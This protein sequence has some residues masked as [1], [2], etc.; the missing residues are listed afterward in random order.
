MK[1]TLSLYA[2][3]ILGLL[4]I[5]G[6]GHFEAPTAS[7]PSVDDE[8]AMWNPQ[9]GEQIDGHAIPLV[10]D[11]YWE[12]QFGAAV[13][14]WQAPPRAIVIGPLGGILRFGPHSL[15]VPA[16]AV[17]SDVLITLSNASTTAI[18]ID[19]GPSP[20]TFNVPVTLVLS[21]MGTQY[22]N[23]NGG[24]NPISMHVYFMAPDGHTEMEPSVVDPSGMTVSGQITH[25]SR[26]ILG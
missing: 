16:G 22:A 21:Y 4:T 11:N 1:T 15:I 9:P 10:N 20:F 5:I 25:F 17:N 2:I 7:Q 19:C 13:N 8:R 18:A 3:L 23:G 6:C 12:S 24:P 14:P 26:Y